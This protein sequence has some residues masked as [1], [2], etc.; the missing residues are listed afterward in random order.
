MDEG[1]TGGEQDVFEDLSLGSGVRN[2]RGIWIEGRMG[3]RSACVTDSTLD[4]VSSR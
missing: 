3:Y 4:G 2:A 1:E